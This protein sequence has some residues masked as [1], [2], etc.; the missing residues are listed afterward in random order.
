MNTASEDALDLADVYAILGY[1]L[2]HR[3][4]VEEYLERN[5]LGG[6]RLRAENERRFPQAGIRELLLTRRNDLANKAS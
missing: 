5:R 1:Y 4:E 2:N 6:E 3:T